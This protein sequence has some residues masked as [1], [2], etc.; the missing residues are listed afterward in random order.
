MPIEK[1][2]NSVDKNLRTDDYY[3]KAGQ[4]QL[5]EDMLELLDLVETLEELENKDFRNATAGQKEV[6]RRRRKLNRKCLE[7]LLDCQ[8]LNARLFKT[9]VL[10]HGES[11]DGQSAKQ[12][13]EQKDQ[14]PPEHPQQD[15]WLPPNHPLLELDHNATSNRYLVDLK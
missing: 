5:G 12:E 14:F 6:E 15:R 11:N 10:G 2:I 7:M 1:I 8:K 13:T 3:K 4:H 9:W